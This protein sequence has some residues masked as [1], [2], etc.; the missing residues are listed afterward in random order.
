MP[1]P[2]T[3]PQLSLAMEEGKVLR[4]LVA[5]GDRVIQG[6]PLVEIETDKAISEVEAPAHGIVRLLASPGAVLGID[7]LLAE[8]L[9]IDEQQ[10]AAQPTS[11]PTAST[12]IETT[13]GPS[14]DP[15]Q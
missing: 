7:S 6:Q 11:T 1:I 4:W 2:V 9:S 13:I 14:R 8:I 3:L 12:T 5:D 15:S 10:D